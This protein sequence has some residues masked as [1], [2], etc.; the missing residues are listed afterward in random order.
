M[1]KRTKK[2]IRRAAKKTI[3]R[4]SKPRKKAIHRRS[5]PRNNPKIQARGAKRTS[6]SKT[7]VR[8]IPSPRRKT[9][10]RSKVARKRSPIRSRL[11]PRYGVSRTF[12]QFVT[13]PQPGRARTTYAI[14]VFVFAYGTREY[15]YHIPVALGLMTKA[16]IQRLTFDD[17]EEAASFSSGLQR[18]EL[19]A[20]LGFCQLKP[21]KA[22]RGRTFQKRVRVRR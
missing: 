16:E 8:R 17:I 1:K 6:K 19:K 15:V 3:R 13:S 22:R 4:R 21:Q 7:R 18:G 11:L 12:R 5:K 20:V 2:A 9:K 10:A 14:C